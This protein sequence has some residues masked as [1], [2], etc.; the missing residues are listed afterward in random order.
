MLTVDV[1]SKLLFIQTDN[2]K[3]T[4]NWEKVIKAAASFNG[5][6]FLEMQLTQDNVPVIVDKCIDFLYA[7]GKLT[8]T[9]VQLTML[10]E[11]V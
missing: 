2:S 10:V 3:V 11:V 8:T 9:N 7:H 6:E 1:I 4:S 5:S